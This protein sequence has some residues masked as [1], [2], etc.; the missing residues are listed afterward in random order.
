MFE[1]SEVQEVRSQTYSTYEQSGVLEALGFNPLFFDG[2]VYKVEED[3]DDTNGLTGKT[4][5]SARG[6]GGGKG[7][8]SLKSSRVK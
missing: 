7:E 4:A 1:A 3:T 8:I 2:P 6:G 5:R